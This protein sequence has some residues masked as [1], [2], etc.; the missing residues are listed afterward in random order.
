EEP[1]HDRL[2]LDLDDLVG[3]GE[4]LGQVARPC[5]EAERELLA[6]RL[7]LERKEAAAARRVRVAPGLDRADEVEAAAVGM[8]PLADPVVV[9]HVGLAAPVDPELLEETARGV[10]EDRLARGDEI[11]ADAATAFLGSA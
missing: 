10:V 6:K 9:D 4:R 7:E 3:L 2:D 11:L 8:F 5:R 1:R